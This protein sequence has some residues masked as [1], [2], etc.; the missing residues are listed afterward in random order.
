VF[1][2]TFGGVG[3]H[4]ELQLKLNELGFRGT[5][6]NDEGDV[7]DGTDYGNVVGICDAVRDLPNNNLATWRRH[8]A[9]LQQD[10]LVEQRMSYQEM[11]AELYEAHPDDPAARAADRDTLW[12]L[13]PPPK[14][15]APL[16]RFKMRAAFCRYDK[17]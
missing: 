16:P 8:L 15:T 6:L 7:E 3:F 1:V 17:E 11:M 4:A 13:P 9:Q 10:Y 12:G 14:L 2:T 5:E